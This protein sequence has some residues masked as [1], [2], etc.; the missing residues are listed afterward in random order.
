M[1]LLA[2][3]ADIKI[4]FPSEA[5]AYFAICLSTVYYS[6]PLGSMATTLEKELASEISLSLDLSP[7]L[8]LPNV[9]IGLI[10]TLF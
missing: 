2:I 7:L 10:G 8:N 6:F 5:V 4:P 3:F 9:P 1:V